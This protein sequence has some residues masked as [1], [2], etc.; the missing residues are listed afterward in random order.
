[1]EKPIHLEEFFVEGVKIK[2]CKRSGYW[3]IYRP[4]TRFGKQVVDIRRKKPISKYSRYF[5]SINGVSKAASHVVAFMKYGRWPDTKGGEVVDHI[6]GD[7]RD[8]SWGNIRITNIHVN[9]MNTHKSIWST[10]PRPKDH[11]ITPL[12]GKKQT[13]WRVTVP[14]IT[15][16]HYGF[17][18][19]T[20]KTYA[21]AVA[22]RDEARALA[23]K[24]HGA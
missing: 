10:D 20:F 5:I 13:T 23:Y 19:K 2:Y 24:L 6:N 4:I 22:L 11:C 14:R 15:R 21:A 3:E 18:N 1:M 17:S 16:A 7:E 9:N 12:H 8:D